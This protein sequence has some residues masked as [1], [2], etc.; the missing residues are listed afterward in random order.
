DLTSAQMRVIGDLA[1]AYSD[2]SVRVTPEQDLVFRWV[3]AGNLRTLYRC[4]SAA[5]LGLAGADTIADVA[6][7]PGAES[8][9][10]A[11]TQSRGLRRGPQNHLRARPDPVVADDG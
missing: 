8:C 7:C 1:R 11:V 6:S 9:R 5:G 10:L 2:G 3:N 4:L